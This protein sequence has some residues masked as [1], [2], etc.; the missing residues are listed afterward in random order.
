MAKTARA[1]TALVAAL[2]SEDQDCVR[3]AA[4]ALANTCADHP[5]NKTKIIAVPSALSELT[6]CR[7]PPVPRDHVVC[8]V[9][10]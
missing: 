6:R 8:R 2:G 4:A 3:N 7:S 5:D 10:F 9:W 1:L